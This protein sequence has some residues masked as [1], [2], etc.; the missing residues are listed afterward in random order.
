MNTFAELPLLPSIQKS[1]ESLG[2]TTPTDIQAKVIP[3]LL[4]NPM[5]DIHA[6]AQTGTGKTLAFG[7]PLLQ[8]IDVTQKDVQALIVAPT[9]ELVVQTYESLRDIARNMGITIE[10]IY[11]GMPIE[12]QIA[13]LRRGAQI[14][15]GTPGRLNDHLRRKTLSLDALKILVLDEADIMLDMGFREEIEDI[16]SAGRK[17]RHI[18]LFSAT[19]MSGIHGLIQS[20]MKNVERVKAAEKSVASSQVKQYYC[21]VPRAKRFEV[22]AR[23][24][25]STPDF[26]GIIFCQTKILSSE[27]MENLVSKGIRAN[28]LHGDMTQALRNRVIKG[29]KAKDFN[30][31]VATDVAAR[32]I[33]VSD[34]TH[35][36]N[37]S[38][39]EEHESYIHRIGRTGRA[40]KE[41][42][43]I[44]LVTPSEVYR[45]KRLEKI[46]G[47][48]LEEIPVPTIDTIIKSK[49]GAVSDFIEQ[50]KKPVANLSPVHTALKEVIASFSDEEIRQSLALALE[51]KF[52]KDVSHEDISV[53][54]MS[55]EPTV[56]TQEICIELGHDQGLQES[57]V[58][59]YLATTC[60]LEANDIFKVRVLNKKTFIAVAENR[61]HDCMVALR[62]TPISQEK[63]KVYM[64]EDTYRPGAPRHDRE[65][66]S[67]GR[68]ERRFRG[69]NRSHHGGGRFGRGDRRRGGR[70]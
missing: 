22:V 19:V 21:V 69:G 59:E 40:G 62:A 3:I 65:H 14:I 16:L 60:K 48:K 9:R 11:G 34:L 52:F 70:R 56:L 4:A 26:Y 63:Y 18:W 24:I 46:A 39:P 64:V 42:I 20:H 35:V 50:A 25:E 12:R 1:L 6:Q 45:I 33:D 32:G 53:S 68:G 27:V 28:C 37:F 67:G 57:A 43:A 2:F 23:F 44:L 5:T 54:V 49:M 58:R 13:N 47:T 8:A 55:H 31:L 15:V 17:D 30:I 38:L 10:P 61:L 41:G 29:F 66:R 7:L 51:D 36:I